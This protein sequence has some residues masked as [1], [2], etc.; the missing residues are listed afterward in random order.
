[1]SKP[2]LGS[3]STDA[4]WTTLQIP[5]HWSAQQ[6]LAVWEFL[7]EVARY[8][9]DRYEMQLVELIRDDLAR[10]DD[11]QPDPLEPDDDIPF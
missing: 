9:W 11:A 10:N 7:D 3:A 8:V 1:M 5:T 2:A 6:A 4:S